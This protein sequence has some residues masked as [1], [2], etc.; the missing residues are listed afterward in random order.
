MKVLKFGGSSVADAT[1]ISRSLDIIE[2]SARAGTTVVISSAIKGCTDTLIRIGELCAARDILWKKVAAELLEK[3]FSI[4]RR[5]FSGEEDEAVRKKV[6]ELFSELQSL[7]ENVFAQGAINDALSRRFQTFG[8]LFSTT[9]IAAKLSGEGWES[10]WLDSRNLVRKKGGELDETLTYSNIAAALSESARIFVAPGFVA[11]D[12]M[13]LPTTLGRG[14]SDYSAAIFAAAAKAD[15]LEIWTD[16]PGM[17]TANP[18]VVSRARTITTLSYAAA[19]ELAAHGAKVLYAPTVVP[20]MKAGIAFSIRNTFDP[21][22]PG[23]VISS[24]VS[25]VPVWKGVTSED[26]GDGTARVVLVGEKTEGLPTTAHRILRALE[27]SGIKALGPVETS[28]DSCYVPVRLNV[29]DNAVAAIHREFFEDKAPAVTDIFIAGWGSVA[30][31]LV[32]LISANGERIARSSGRR[33]RISGVSDSRRFFVDLRGTE[34]ALVGKRLDEEG[35][36]AADGAFVAEILAAA[37]RHSVFVDCTDSLDLFEQYTALFDKGVNIVTSNRR[38]IAVPYV[39][40]AAMKVSAAENGCTFRYDTTVGTALPILESVAGSANCSDAI[41]SIEAV[42]SCTM[43]NILTSYDGSESLATL[44]RRAQD[45]GLTERDPRTDLGG[46][47]ALRKLL[48][49]AREAG[50]PLEEEDVEIVPVLGKEY[51]ECGLDEFYERL[52]DAEPEFVKRE[53]ELDMMGRRQRFVA[54]LRRDPS[55]RCG[56][57]AGI[58]MQPVG[59]DSPFYWISGTENVTVIRSE[60]SAPLVIRGAG[61]GAREAASGV[62]NDIL[63]R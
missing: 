7:G 61:E 17:M 41:L 10:L 20:A 55:A 32:E 19:M 8:E 28:S 38:S 22:N 59:V 2:T 63:K 50:M 47:D 26:M 18:K 39:K 48:I 4:I 54:S 42:L 56:F 35:R 33:I 49:I 37:P 11:R 29:A 16:V 24:A 14:G 51:F 21:A 23:T 5:L 1:A 13:G 53:A 62:L 3:H 30:R 27:D 34:P 36:C 25:E 15:A 43:N 52:E 58:S 60:N 46:R 6:E 31:S 40:Y 44:L 57:K 12:E 45:S 9:I